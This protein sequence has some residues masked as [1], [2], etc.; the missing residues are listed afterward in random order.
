VKADLNGAR[1]HY[2][3]EGACFPI[4]M[5]HAGVAD[6]RMWQPQMDAFTK[7][8][9][10][11]RPDMRGFGDSGLPAGPWKPRDDLL[12]LMDELRLKPAHLVGCSM[13]GSLAIDFAIDH[14]E[15]ISKL[16][17]VGA[18]VSGAKEDPRHEGLY[19]EVM[20][21]DERGDMAV[22]EGEMYLW[23]DGPYRP[24]GYVAQPLRDLFL[25]MNGKNLRNDWSK[26]PMQSLE[27]P[28]AG[29]LTEITAPTLVI[30][31]DADLEPIRETADLLV[32]SISG[33]RK[34]VIHDAAHLPNLEHPGEFNR[35]VLDFLRS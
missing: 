19:A 8:F 6:S 13:G 1:I 35:I 11:V 24:R 30:V 25:D 23:L 22:N 32:S 18:G 12:A 16:V 9:D 28:A 17:L 10:V 3:R 26:S 5:L 2:R 33:A 29:R 15:R 4:V 20:A 34:M 31:G 14:P 21:A 27:P 7:D